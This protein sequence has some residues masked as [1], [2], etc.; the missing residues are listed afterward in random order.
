MLK[1]CNV[2]E[3]GKTAQKVQRVEGVQWK[4]K[5]IQT[6][7]TLWRDRVQRYMPQSPEFSRQLTNRTAGASN[8]PDQ[9]AR[10]ELSETKCRER[11]T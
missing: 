10:R 6:S 5:R 11:E 3:Q 2:G 4:N 1:I 7:Q 8:E 9:C